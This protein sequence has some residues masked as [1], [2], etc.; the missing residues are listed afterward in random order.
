MIKSITSDS[1]VGVDE[2]LQDGGGMS[3]S[4]SPGLLSLDTIGEADDEGNEDSL[5]LRLFIALS[6]IRFFSSMS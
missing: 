5:T 2:G 6:S 1:G 4:S 3:L